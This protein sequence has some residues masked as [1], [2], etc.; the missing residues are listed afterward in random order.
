MMLYVTMKT[1]ATSLQHTYYSVSQAIYQVVILFKFYVIL[2][3]VH[4]K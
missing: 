4:T 1:Y 3:S 2:E